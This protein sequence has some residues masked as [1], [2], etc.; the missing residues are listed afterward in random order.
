MT[1]WRN[2]GACNQASVQTWCRPLQRCVQILFRYVSFGDMKIKVCYQNCPTTRNDDWF[3][4][5]IVLLCLFGSYKMQPATLRQE[6][7]PLPS[8][9]RRNQEAIV[10][11]S[12]RTLGEMLKW[13]KN[14]KWINETF[15]ESIKVSKYPLNWQEFGK[16]L[17]LKPWRCV[18]RISGCVSCM[19][20]RH[21]GRS[22]FFRNNRRGMKCLFVKLL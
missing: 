21:C 11:C 15:Q 6:V 5:P 12:R 13:I 18:F 3:L 9:P 17:S 10:C 7:V 20:E 14:I 1:W 16:F 2:L 22:W 8:S 19:L 4:F